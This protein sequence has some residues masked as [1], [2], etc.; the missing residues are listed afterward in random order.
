MQTQGCF[1]DKP[2]EEHRERLRRLGHEVRLPGDDPDFA[3]FLVR[4]GIASISV[5][6]D[7]FFAV[8]EN[9]AAAEAEVA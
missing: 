6:P 1:L 7:S 8:K 9:V 2:S 4:A 5:A 3:R